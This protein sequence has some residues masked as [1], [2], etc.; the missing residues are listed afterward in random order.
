MAAD[1]A[2]ARAL[3]EEK[4]AE[5]AIP[6]VALGILSGDEEARAGFG[7]TSVENPLPVTAETL[8]Q[9]GSITKTFLGTLVMRLAQQGKLDL[10]VPVRT[11]V[12]QLRLRSADATARVTLRH[13]LTHTAGWFGDHFEDFGW[14]DDALARYVAFMA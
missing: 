12:P 8:F 7:V 11:Y 5:D 1:L 14:G 6:G 4:Q 2:T 3:V 10:D 13:C 9:V